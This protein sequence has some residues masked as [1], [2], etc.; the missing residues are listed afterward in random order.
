MDEREEFEQ[1]INQM[2]KDILIIVEGKKDLTALKKIGFTN[3]IQLKGP[4]FEAVE[5]VSS[6]TKVVCILTDLDNEGKK[7]YSE[8]SKGLTRN[9]VKIDNTLRNFLFKKTTLRQIEGMTSYFS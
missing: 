7:I 4:L 5:N 3:V 1:L 9:G 2:P 8:L 6:R